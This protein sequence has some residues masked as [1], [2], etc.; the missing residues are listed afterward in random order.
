MSKLPKLIAQ[1]Y[2][3]LKDLSHQHVMY[4]SLTKIIFEDTATAILYQDGQRIM[5]ATMAD[6]DALADLITQFFRHVEPEIAT[7]AM[8]F[9]NLFKPDDG[10]ADLT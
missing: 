6:P 5:S 10:I 7:I 8:M 4:E 9:V 1:Y 2:S 3:D